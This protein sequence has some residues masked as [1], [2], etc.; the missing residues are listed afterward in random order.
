[1]AIDILENNVFMPTWDFG[2]MGIIAV[3][4]LVFIGGGLFMNM[5]Y[6]RKNFLVSI[7]GTRM[8][9]D[10]TVRLDGDE[11]VSDNIIEILFQNAAVG[12]DIKEFQ[13][14]YINGKPKYLAAS[15]KRHLVPL[16]YSNNIPMT[17]EKD[18]KEE[19]TYVNAI[20][21]NEITTGN[22]IAERN[23]EL[24]RK[25]KIIADANKTLLMNIL[26]VAPIALILLATI[27]GGYIGSKAI[28]D[29]Q[30]EDVYP[31]NGAVDSLTIL[32]ENL[33]IM[34]NQTRP[35]R[36]VSPEATGG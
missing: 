34:Y 15:V 3:I 16:V 27:I 24:Q 14:L 33:A 36:Y 11:I 6:P 4:F 26:V 35:K 8:F 13:Q 2:L 5:K 28:K 20:I 21:P 25:K 1:M 30:K 19:L 23:I 31:L 12:E 22:K 10:R 29:A 9:R 17:I 7:D 32:N 18:G